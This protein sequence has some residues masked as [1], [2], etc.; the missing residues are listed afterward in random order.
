M[1]ESVVNSCIDE[2]LK[3]LVDEYKKRVEK[4]QRQNLLSQYL[5]T[6][7]GID[8]KAGVPRG[9]TFI[10]V[11]HEAPPER[12]PEVFERAT[13][14][15]TNLNA[16]R[17]AGLTTN[18]T[19]RSLASTSGITANNMNKLLNLFESQELQLTNV[20]AESLKKL[21]IKRF[22]DANAER[23]PFAIGDKIVVADFYLPY[24][25]CSDCPPVAYILPKE[26]KPVLEALSIKLNKTDFCNNDDA[27]Y[28]ITASPEGGKLT[29]SGGGVDVDK[30]ELRPK[31]VPAGLVKITY[32][33][34]DGRTTSVDVKVSAAFEIDFNTEQI[35]DNPF[36]IRFVPNIADR[37]L[38]WNFGDNTAPSTEHQPVHTYQITGD[39]QTFL[40]TLTVVEGPCTI[41]KEHVVTI[42]RPRPQI[43][44]IRPK[45]FCARDEAPKPFIIEPAV[46]DINEIENPDRLKLF[47]DN[48]VI[49]FKPTDQALTATK[50]FRLSYK[51]I[52]VEIKVIVPDASFFME[53]QMQPGVSRVTDI[54]LIL[55]AK[56]TDASS[57]RWMVTVGQNPP[58]EFTEK[59]IR[60]TYRQ[61][62]ANTDLPISIVL[63]INYERE[64]RVNCEDKKDYVL[65]A[66]IARNHLNRGE[67]DNLT[68]Q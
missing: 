58:I 6:N 48:N 11:Y 20:Q 28:K 10:I 14:A 44:D 33:L 12:Q 8:H 27:V 25:C 31:D 47:S 2:R 61:L 62:R 63:I 16:V 51:T 7:P 35:A 3:A 13:G 21:V 59:E 53:L 38:S 36:A 22:A 42:R 65:T 26:D 9:G 15:V 52:P 54:I 68:P 30:F 40:A 43:F 56:Q 49:F 37:Q 66:A 1:L 19:A 64:T 67:F 5:K 46:Q 45:I 60:T 23:D 17:E 24:L 18:V 50:T 41:K 39:E 57:Y 55:K 4:V 34:D 29:A 32:T